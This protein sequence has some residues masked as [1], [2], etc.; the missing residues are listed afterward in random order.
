MNVGICII[1]SGK[2]NKFLTPLLESIDRLFLNS[3]NRNVFLFSDSLE[4]EFINLNTFTKI[5]FLPPPLTTLLRFN[6]FCK[7]INKL[8]NMDVIY[9][10]DVD[11]LVVDNVN[12][13][14]LP[15]KPG[16][17]VGTIH[18]WSNEVKINSYETNIESTAY[19][20]KYDE[21]PYYQ[22][23][24]FGGYSKDF[25]NMTIELDNNIKSDLK[26][27]LIAKWYDESHMNRY[28]RKHP[29]K[30][31]SPSYAYPVGQNFNYDKKIIHH[32]FHFDDN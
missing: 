14:I 4:K 12:V 1:S 16:Q 3:F 32:A 7:I 8:N 23:C 20:E 29:P 28:F 26:K 27:N 6:Y 22:G 10:M 24:F 18:P 31:L 30:S 21:F 13:E 15:D 17:L 5:E 19:V 9:Y 11:C 2:Y 25:I